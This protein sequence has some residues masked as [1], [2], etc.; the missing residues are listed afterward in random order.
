MPADGDPGEAAP[1]S[2]QV[3]EN[4]VRNRVWTVKKRTSRRRRRILLRVLLGLGIVSI[5]MGAPAGWLALRA[6]E[7][8]DELT[9]VQALAPQFQEELVRK[10]TSSARQTLDRIQRHATSAQAAATDPLWKAASGLPVAGANF[11]A[12]TEVAVAADDVVNGAAQPLL[13]VADSVSWESLAPSNGRF[14]I[15]PLRRAAPRIVAAANTVELTYARL[16]AI[17]GSRLLGQVAEPLATTTAT[18]NDVREALTDAAN[19]S[20]ILPSM[21]GANGAR[22]YLILV[23]NNAEVRATGGLAGALAVLRVD[24]GVL[25]LAAQSSGSAMQKFT[26]PSP[27]DPTQ[28]RIYTE[29]LGTYIGDVNLTPHFPTAAKTAKSMWERRHGTK[30]D[31]V[32]ALD[33]VVLAHILGAT[34]PISIPPSSQLPAPEGTLPSKLTSANAVQTLLSDVYAKVDDTAAH[35]AYFAFVAQEIFQGLTSGQGSGEKM[36]DALVQSAAENRVY[37]WSDVKEEQRIIAAT[38]LSGSITGPAAGGAAFG[39]YFNDGTGAKMDYYVRRTVQLIQRC[40]QN[41]LSQ[42]SVRVTLKNTAPA[43]AA[44]SLPDA[45][46]GAGANGTKPG[47]IKTDTLLYGPTQS[48]IYA[49]SVNGEKVPMG[50]FQHASR[51]VGII[52]TELA[53]GRSATIEFD[54]AR[55]VQTELPPLRVTPTIQSPAEVVRPLAV[56]EPCKE[57]P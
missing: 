1:Q 20:R 50:S 55:V 42:Y 34:G 31:G 52:R 37:V 29:R 18:L 8:R 35:D 19:A 25:R 26:P 56:G 48:L 17:D 40:R 41:G 46:T 15:A 23:Q 10:D 39:V 22:N 49:S 43:D 47:N 54:V 36:I 4:E 6:V 9:A 16:A 5:V 32:V 53:P 14:D 51:P 2:A 13:E 38:P 7:I 45:V 11:A 27:V 21:L 57:S 44:T 12:V 3:P 30:I 24:D 28:E 33:P